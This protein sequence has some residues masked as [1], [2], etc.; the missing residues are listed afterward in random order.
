MNEVVMT[1]IKRNRIHPHKL[2]L[3]IA[4]ASM[5]MLFGAFT[6]AYIVRQAAGNWLEFRIPDIFY[7]SSAVIIGSS[8]LL[9]TS[10]RS[11]L[12][13][14]DKRYKILLVATFFAAVAFV[15]LQYFGW[16]ALYDIGVEL[17]GNPSGSFFYVISWMHLMHVLGGMTAL[18]VALI[19]A[20]G[21]PFKVTAKRKLRFQL[22][23][24][25]WH[26]LGALWIYLFF[27]LL[28]Q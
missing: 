11:F 25:F 16:L 3:W 1:E 4:M 5:M 20:F 8:I 19:H 26:F 23:V 15:I 6:S 22:V 24:Q 14:W 17:T 12:A 18:I 21:L 9:E 28:M 2:A 7:V 10:Y 13:G 27:F